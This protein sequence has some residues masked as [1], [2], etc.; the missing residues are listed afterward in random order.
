MKG[1][2]QALARALLLSEDDTVDILKSR[3][4]EHLTAEKA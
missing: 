4:E 3:I 1:D 2:L